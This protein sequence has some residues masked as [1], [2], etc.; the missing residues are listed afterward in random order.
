MSEF[1]TTLYDK[2]TLFANRFF[3]SNLLQVD[4]IVY[5]IIDFCVF[6][7]KNFPNVLTE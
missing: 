2:S 3:K 6:F 1:N 7:E 4:S 5:I